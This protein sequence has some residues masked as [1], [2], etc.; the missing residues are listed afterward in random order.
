MVD[1]SRIPPSEQAALEALLAAER[2]RVEGQI[3]A[4]NR[5]FAVIVDS[6]AHVCTDDEHDPE[7]STTAFERAQVAALLR[8]ARNHLADLD[9]AFGRLRAGRYGLCDRCGHPI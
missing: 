7:G 3:V 4:L 6:S 2:D 8:Q 5:D 1:G 9:D